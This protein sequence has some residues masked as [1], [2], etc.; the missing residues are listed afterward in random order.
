MLSWCCVWAYRKWALGRQVLDVPNA[1]SSHT[2][3]TPRGGGVGIVAVVLAAEA[4]G[5]QIWPN[6]RWELLAALMAG[7]A[8]ALVSWLDDLRGLSARVRL[9]I[10]SLG[11]IAFTATFLHC[12]ETSWAEHPALPIGMALW[13]VAMTNFFNFMDG[14]DGL[15]GSQFFITGLSWSTVGALGGAEATMIL[16]AVMAAAAAGFLCFNWPPATIFMGDVGSAFCGFTAAVMPFIAATDHSA[17]AGETGTWWIAG[18][19]F[20][21][22]FFFDASTTLFRRAL[23]GEK[24]WEPH[25]SHLYQRLTRSGWSHVTVTGIY[26]AWATFSSLVGVTFITSTLAIAVLPLLLASFVLLFVTCRRFRKAHPN[27]TA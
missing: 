4:I 25:R 8:I 18:V 11:A 17:A 21:F 13:I 5:V 14:I 24:I 20:L 23:A 26:I 6:I 2:R 19:I 7:L 27:I 15:A 9:G 10:H 3:P 1:R 22:P 16:G 12:A